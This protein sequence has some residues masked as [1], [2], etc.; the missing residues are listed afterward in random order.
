[1]ASLI[2]RLGPSVR[3]GFAEPSYTYC[4]SILTGYKIF[5]TDRPKPRG[6][7]RFGKNDSAIHKEYEKWLEDVTKRRNVAYPDEGAYPDKVV[8]EDMGKQRCPDGDLMAGGFLAITMAWCERNKIP[9]EGAGTSAI[10]LLRRQAP[11]SE[12]MGNA[13]S[14][15][16][17]PITG[18]RS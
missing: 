1:M 8:F 4:D 2:L 16:I 10:E 12:A 6:Q 14:R 7:K 17:S 5:A 15:W 13:P 18:R 9:Y 11:R 3:Y